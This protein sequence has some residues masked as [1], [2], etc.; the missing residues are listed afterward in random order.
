MNALL[1]VKE[2][3]H[4]LQRA[5]ARGDGEG[6]ASALTRLDGIVKSER[7]GL[8]PRLIHF[9]ERR[10]YAKA[11]AFIEEEATAGGGAADS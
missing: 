5:T 6:I 4:N 9:L 3:L 2:E 7:K 1:T 10:S 8:P 11:E